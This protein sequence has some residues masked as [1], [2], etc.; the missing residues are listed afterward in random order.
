MDQII[1]S[2][3]KGLFNGL[4]S[5]EG[6]RLHCVQQEKSNAKYFDAIDSGF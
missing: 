1:D 4:H 6:E 5:L 2:S 3:E